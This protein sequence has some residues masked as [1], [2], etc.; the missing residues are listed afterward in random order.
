VPV[1]L[2]IHRED[3]YLNALFHQKQCR[4]QDGRMLDGRGN[5]LIFLWICEVNDPF[6]DHIVGFAST[7]RKDD[8]PGLATQ[9]TRHLFPGAVDPF[10]RPHA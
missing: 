9:K 10:P 8:L 7:G 6:E 4:I 5:D 2:L 1:S 3:G